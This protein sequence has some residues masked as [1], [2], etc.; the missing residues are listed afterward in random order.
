MCTHNMYMY[1]YIYIRLWTF[2]I[3]LLSSQWTQAEAS[4]ISSDRICAASLQALSKSCS[5]WG[6]PP[7][8]DFTDER[9]MVKV[10][11]CFLYLFDWNM[12]ILE[13]THHLLI[14]FTTST[15]ACMR[16][17]PQS[18]MKSSEGKKMSRGYLDID[19]CWLLFPNPVK[20]LMISLGASMGPCKAPF[21]NI[22]VSTPQ[23]ASRTAPE[24][25]DWRKKIRE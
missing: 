19:P 5:A 22:S 21:F 6:N 15:I 25:E 2:I 20:L 4:R 1:I 8:R 16:F 7:T 17:Q 18:T 24:M 23:C 10:M 14:G 12:L 9:K 3:T 13:L 11:C